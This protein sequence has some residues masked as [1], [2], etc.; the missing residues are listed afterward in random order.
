[1]STS[2]LMESSRSLDRRSFLKLTALAG[3]GIAFGLYVSSLP[4]ALA[5][6]TSASA[7]EFTPNAFIRISPQGVVTIIAKNPEIG[8]GV[9]TALPMIIA[10]EL[11]VPWEKV[12]VEQASLDSRYGVQSAGGST[13]IPGNYDQG[14]RF[15]AA[16]RVT[17]VNAAAQTW[18]VP[19]SECFAE[20]ATVIHRPS[21]RKLTY[22]EL[23]A[24]AATLPPPDL[25]TVPL[26]DPKDFKIIGRRIGGVDNQK[27]VTGQSLF[28]IDQKRPGMLHAVYVRCPCF[29]GKVVSA[30]TAEIEKLPG[31]RAVFTIAGS[32]D[33]FGLLP[34]VAIVANSTWAAFSAREQLKVTWDES[35]RPEFSSPAFAAKAIE[36]AKG[37]TKTETRHSGSVDEALAAAAK[38]VEAEYHYPYLAHA[39][40]EPQ[41]CTAIFKDG[42][43]EMWSPT[44]TPIPALAT[45]SK[46]LDLPKENITIH[47]V[48]A[49]GS[50]GRRIMN[51]FMAETAAIA[52]KMPGTPIKVTWTRTQ[53]LQHDYY[54]SAGWHFLKGGVDAAGKLTVW[55]ND[56]VTLGTN[57]IE[58][59]GNGGDVNGDEFP[60]RFIPNFRL[61]RSIIESNLPTGYWRAPGSCGYGWAFQS[62][63]DELA[64]AGGRDPVEFRLEILGAD[65]DVPVSGGGRGRPYS[66]TRMKNVLRL[67]AEKAGWGKTQRPRGQGQGVAFHY[68]HAGYVAIVADV[69]VAQDGTLKVDKLTAAVD[70]GPIVNLSGAENQ[71]Q[72]SLIDGLGAAWFLEIT[73]EN[74]RVQQTNY[75]DYPLIRMADSPKIETY[76]IESNNPPTGLGEPALPPVAPAVCNAIFAA[77]GKRIRTLPIQNTDLSW[78]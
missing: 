76:F 19:A 11:E 28:G 32:N 46:A 26:K 66:A 68:S 58:K 48:R 14:R 50:F 33:L 37:T 73:V 47:L 67:A 15:G 49:G 43:L 44:Q 13:A 60:S 38:T 45:V 10:E 57:S 72:G 63:I 52:Q 36:L 34:G 62:F 18:N 39:P 75:A 22:G 24:K 69:T 42:R 23:V 53:D 12:V 31:V 1:M 64:H 56:F 41:N 78:S 59:T 55:H 20:S 61:N 71:V 35:P 6:V 9:K 21:G 17:L 2:S 16:A 4:A 40:L 5:E 27:I 70:V 74:G 8:Q 7:T 29:G 54:R 25:K 65:R 51:D 77:T 3:G 30:N